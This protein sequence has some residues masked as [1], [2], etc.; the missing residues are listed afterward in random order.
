MNVS[1]TLVMIIGFFSFHNEFLSILTRASMSIHRI[2]RYYFPPIKKHK[3]AFVFIFLLYGAG[4]ILSDVLRPFIYKHLIDVVTADATISED[5][6]RQL[7]F[8]I[9]L[10]GGIIVLYNIFYRTSDYVMTYFQG[11]ALKE[12]ADTAFEKIH[13]HSYAFF[14]NTFAGALVA[15]AKRFVRAFE[16]LH[17]ETVYSLFFNAV[18]LI[19]ISA[20]L[21]FTAPT[22]ALIFILWC[23][24]YVGTTTLFIRKKIPLDLAMA[25]ADSAVTASLADTITNALTVKMFSAFGKEMGVF[26]GVTDDEMR[27]RNRAWYF[28]NFMYLVQAALIGSLEFAGMAV[29]VKLW[30]IGTITAGTVVLIQIY[31]LAVFG[32]LWHL[33]QSLTKITQSLTDAK[34]MVDIFEK[35]L[36][37]ADP[38]KPEVCHMTNGH[39]VFDAVSFAYNGGTPVFKNFSLD[40]APGEKIGIVGRSG[41]G[42][43]T[44]TKLLLRFSDIQRGS[45]TIDNQDIRAITQDDLRSTISYVPQDPI[46]FHRTLRENILYGNPHATEKD[47]IDASRKAHA[48]AFISRL[49]HGYD[50]LVGERGIKLSGGER[51]RIAIARAILKDSPILMLDE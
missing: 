21:L 30:A 10:L 7:F 36:D 40:V 32:H 38:E 50:T 31:I 39:I 33:G 14:T 23:F 1:V 24:L 2:L 20:A 51:Q 15:K 46:L 3:V 6:A 16:N 41:V 47:M 12:I 11:R 34:E 18:R 37:V 44:I 29:A 42:K 17:D 13:R 43:S 9:A 25:N 8:L 22:I 49:P 5:L 48:H 35:E 26:A 4:V 19:G 28:Q 45:I 27:K